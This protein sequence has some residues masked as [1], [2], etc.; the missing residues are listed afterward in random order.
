MLLPIAV[1]VVLGALGALLVA[2]ATVRVLRRL[3]LDPVTVMLW[4][5]LAERPLELPR[6][7]RRRLGELLLDATMP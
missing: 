6:R 7:R 5:G 3:G 4:L 2:R 1:L